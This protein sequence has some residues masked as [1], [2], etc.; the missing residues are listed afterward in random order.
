MVNQINERN[1]E[2]DRCV[3]GMSEKEYFG[4]KK[5]QE[6]KGEI[7]AYSI[8]YILLFGFLLLAYLL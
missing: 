8:F 6:T 1:N 5:W 2:L 7:I 3:F 4:N